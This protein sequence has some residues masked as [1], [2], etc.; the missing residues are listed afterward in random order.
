MRKKAEIIK[1]M[2]GV[3]QLHDRVT[4]EVGQTYARAYNSNDQ[5]LINEC[6]AKIDVFRKTEAQLRVLEVE[7][8]SAKD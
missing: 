6:N 4:M 7:L 1:E 3:Q 8:A 5:K 2:I